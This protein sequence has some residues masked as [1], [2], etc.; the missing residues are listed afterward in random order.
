[1]DEMDGQTQPLLCYGIVVASNLVLLLQA[2]VLLCFY[3]VCFSL[4]GE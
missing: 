1:M 4:C 3:F 2:T